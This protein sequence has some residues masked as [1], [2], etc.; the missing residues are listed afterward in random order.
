MEVPK[1]KVFQCREGHHLC[2]ECYSNCTSCPQCRAPFEKD[3]RIRTLVVE[4]LL[5]DYSLECLNKKSGCKAELN[6]KNFQDHVESCSFSLGADVWKRWEE[7]EKTKKA[8]PA[9]KVDE[10]SPRTGPSF[11]FQAT[12]PSPAFALIPA[13]PLY[14]SPTAPSF[15]TVPTPQVF[16]QVGTPPFVNGNAINQF[17][18]PNAATTFQLPKTLFVHGQ[19]GSPNGIS[20]PTPGSP[21]F[22][23]NG[24]NVN[25]GNVFQQT[26]MQT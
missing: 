12:P 21:V 19:F 15:V 10:T 17:P 1:D 16:P 23:A 8:T 7:W 2:E 11:C 25:L 5:D 22:F 9:T 13:A 3:R 6:R 14:H 20:F 4:A 26:R 24:G 18:T